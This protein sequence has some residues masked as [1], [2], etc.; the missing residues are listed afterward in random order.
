MFARTERLL[1][2][3]G[4]QEDAPAL[5]RAIGEE[6]VVRN[7]ATAPWPYGEAQ[8]QA[9]LSQPIDPMQPRFLIFARTGG[10]PRLVGGCGISPSPEDGLEMGYWIA[11]PYWGL[12]FATEAGRQLIRIARALHLPR[13]S[14][15]HFLDNPASGA[16][17]RKLGFRPTGQIAQR[18][19]L[20]RGGD[21]AV[22]LFEEGDADADGLVTPM[23]SRIGVDED[24]REEL[25]LMAA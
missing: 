9:F 7:L 16:V 14:A 22:A 6:A 20:A 17:L 8:A 13:L 25:R 11:R 2:R 24:F 21:A 18:F 12:G 23:R 10:A 5:A 1:L 3:P 4:W 19:S 15:G